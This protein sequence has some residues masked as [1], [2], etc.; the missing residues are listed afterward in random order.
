MTSL[1]PLGLDDM[2]ADL[3]QLLAP[4]VERLGYLGAFFSLAGHQAGA[5]QQAL[6]YA[7]TLKGT[8]TQ[9]LVEVIALAVSAEAQN[10]YE[11]V[12]HERLA[13][14]LGMTPAEVTAITQGSADSCPQLSELERAV[15]RLSRSV[16]RSVGHEA[17]ADFERVLELSD[18]EVAVGSLLMAC[19]YLAFSAVAN[20]WRLAAPVSSPLDGEAPDA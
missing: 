1:V 4:R 14:K 13:L 3:R 12:Q 20:T 8:L 18:P 11:R 10:P 6:G 7:E 19:H 16:V 5:L 2:P 17:G 9:R 15:W